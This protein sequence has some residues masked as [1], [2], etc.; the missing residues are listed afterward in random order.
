M[1]A[2]DEIAGY[3]LTGTYPDEWDGLGF[4][5]GWIQ[6]LGVRRPWRGRGLAKALLQ[7]SSA[8]FATA[9]LEYA[10]LDVDADSPTGAAQLYEGLGFR[11]TKTRVAWSLTV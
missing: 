3:S 4:S 1:L 11:P 2:G 10:A 8:A 6:Q 5:E 7:A 9:G